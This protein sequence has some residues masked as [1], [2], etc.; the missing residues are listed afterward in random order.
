MQPNKIALLLIFLFSF[1]VRI[2]NYNYPPLTWDEASLGYNSYSISQTL[3]DEYGTFLPLIFKSFGDYKPGL[4]IY[5]ASLF[6]PIFG[7]TE[8]SVR[9]PSIILGSLTPILL[10]YFVFHFSSHHKILAYLSALVLAANPYNIHFSRGAWET[11]ILTF[12]LILASYLFFKF[13]HQSKYKYL[14][15]SSLVFAATLYTYQAGKLISFLLVIVLWI[16]HRTLINKKNLSV[17]FLPLTLL[18][19]PIIFGL[20]SQSDANRLKVV[21][22]L[23]YP[24][25]DTEIN[26]IQSETSTLD[27]Q[28]F[29]SRPLFFL[30]QFLF[31]YFNHFSPRFLTFEGDWQNPRHSAPYIGMLLFPSCLFLVLGIIRYLHEHPSPPLDRFFFAWFLLAPIPAA[32]TR[33]TIQAVR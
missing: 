22:L 32:L 9:L 11:N 3:R 12:E 28:L 15:L 23:S 24:Q 14:L 5:L 18:I 17:F 2:W 4:Y 20:L 7:L 16:L 33:D 13:R 1:L 26:Q 30:R 29:H 6:T 10:F 8:L 31:R 27:Y 19:L 21:S 25:P